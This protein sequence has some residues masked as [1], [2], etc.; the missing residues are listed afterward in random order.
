MSESEIQGLIETMLRRELT[1]AEEARWR[2]LEGDPNTPAAWREE[3]CLSRLV[4]RLPP[5]V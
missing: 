5:A 1:P 4:R 3:A 2:R